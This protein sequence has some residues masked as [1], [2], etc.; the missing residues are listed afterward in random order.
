MVERIS[1]SQCA[2]LLTFATPHKICMNS[3]RSKAAKWE[4]LNSGELIRIRNNGKFCRSENCENW[5]YCFQSSIVF[6]WIEPSDG[7]SEKGISIEANSLLGESERFGIGERCHFDWRWEQHHKW[8]ID[9][10]VSS[11]DAYLFDY[12]YL[13]SIPSRRTIEW[14]WIYYCDRVALSLVVFRS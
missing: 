6:A 2:S 14:W 1:M 4:R 12:Y 9:E 10:S 8:Q 11:A 7:N 5:L 13:D 3:M